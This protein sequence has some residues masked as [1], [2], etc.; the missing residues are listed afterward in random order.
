MRHKQRPALDQGN[1][2]GGS[3]EGKSFHRRLGEGRPIDEPSSITPGSTF[4]MEF[5]NCARGQQEQV[6]SNSIVKD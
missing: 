1:Q 6:D 3:C 4:P 5:H 2:T